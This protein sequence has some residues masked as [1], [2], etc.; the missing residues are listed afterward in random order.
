MGIKAKVIVGV[1]TV[2]I[3]GLATLLGVR[4]KRGQRLEK[5][6]VIISDVDLKEPKEEEEKQASMEDKRNEIEDAF[7]KA[8]LNDEADAYKAACKEIDE[9]K[10]NVWMNSEQLAILKK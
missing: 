5:V 1:T 3:G 6:N 10:K 4:K 9:T 2:V 8:G 7:R